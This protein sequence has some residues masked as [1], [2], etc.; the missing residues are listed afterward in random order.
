MSIR[1]ITKRAWH[2]RTKIA[3][4][5]FTASLAGSAL[6]QA[7][8]PSKPITFIVP[9][10]T[11]SASDVALRLVAEK[12]AI[13]LKQPV[14]ID[15]QTGASGAIGAERVARA[16]ADG[17]TLCGCNNAILS[18]L[19]HLRKVG[20]DPVKSYRPVGMVAVLPT[21]LLVS[22]GMPIRSVA[23]LT[24]YVKANPSVATYASGGVGSPQHIAM[25]MY[26]ATA[27]I[28]LVHVP[29]KGA[30]PAAVGLAGGE[31]NAMFNAIGTVLPLIK[32]GKLRPI[33]AAGAARAPA[34]PDLPTM[35][36]SGVPGYDYAS[37]IGLTVPAGTPD[38]IVTRLNTELVKILRSPEMATRF[39]EQGLDPFVTTPQQMADYLQA[40]IPR[41]AKAIKDAGIQPE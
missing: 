7:P 30:S 19:P 10:A 38:E 2:A 32:A 12:L 23:E 25:A 26:E 27:G 35:Q 31:V 33:A 40:D 8:Y 28:R 24:A 13:A 37:W 11:G 4:A 17:Y 41:M 21:V 20:Y 6:A 5:L 9:L 39:A 22:T 16:A 18:V 34:F 29:Y 15:N 1:N 14:L 36:E 3:A